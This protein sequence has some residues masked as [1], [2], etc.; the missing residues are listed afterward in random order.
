VPVD[1]LI[2]QQHLNI[3]IKYLNILWE[4]HHFHLQKTNRYEDEIKMGEA[5]REMKI[6][7]MVEFFKKKSEERIG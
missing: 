4:K 5:R 3:Q 1:S 6:V 2:F 7:E